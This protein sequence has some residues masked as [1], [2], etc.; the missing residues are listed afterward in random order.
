MGLGN[1]ISS[2]AKS[3]ISLGKGGGAK[4]GLGLANG[5]VNTVF[6]A[7]GKCRKSKK[8]KS[9]RRK[10]SKGFKGKGSAAKSAQLANGIVNTV[11]DAI[12]KG[13]SFKGKNA[14]SGANPF[15]T[16][17]ININTSKE[18]DSNPCICSS[19]DNDLDM[20]HDIVDTVFDSIGFSFEESNSVGLKIE[21]GGFI[22]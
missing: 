1:A 6:S 12:N 15:D 7:I 18:N 8:D 13:K 21:G 3:G 2:I 5:I 16:I 11:F 10:G 4:A 14:K 22:G 19:G 20:A 9:K 17:N